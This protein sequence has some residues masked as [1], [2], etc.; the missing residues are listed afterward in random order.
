MHSPAWIFPK[1][2]GSSS[3]VLT[4]LDEEIMSKAASSPSRTAVDLNGDWGKYVH[5]KLMDTVTVPSSLRPSGLY[6]LRRNFLLPRLSNIQRAF[7]H[8][9][10]INYHGRVF[11]NGQ[12]LGTTIAFLPHEFDFTKV[13]TEGSNTVEVQIADALSEP[14]GTGKDDIAFS[15]SGGWEPS[16]G[17]IRDAYVEVR[18]SAF[19]DNVRFGYKLGAGYSSAA[20]TAKV[21]VSSA[22]AHSGECELSLWWRNTEIAQGK[23]ALDLTPGITEA[24][25]KFDVKTLAL[26]SPEDP[27]LYELR[28]TLTTP[29][30]E[31]RWKTRTGFREIKTEGRIFV[32][33]G[34]RFVMNGICRHDTWKDQGFT[35]SRQ[36]QEKD[37]RM[38]KAMGCNFVRLV[39]Y[40][41]DRRIIELADEIGLFVSEEPGFYGN[42][43]FA[44][45]PSTEIDLG[46]HILQGEIRRDWNSPSVMIWLLGNECAFPVSYLKKGKTICDQL[47]PIGRLVS[48]AHTYGNFPGVKDTFDEAGMDFYDWH[49]YEYEDGKFARLAKS[50]GPDKPLTFTEWGWEVAGPKAVFYEPDFDGLLELVEAG[51]VAGHAFW[52]WNDVR[53][54]NRK[55]WSATNGLLRSGAVTEDREIRQPIYGRL[56]ALF[57][58]RREAENRPAPERPT[59]LPLRTSPFVPGSIFQITDLQPLADSDSGRLSWHALQGELENFWGSTRMARNQWKRTGAKFDLWQTP[60]VKIAGVVF[61]S[62]LVDGR[63]RPVVLTTKVSEVTI[64]IQQFCTALHILGQVSFGKGY[65]LTGAPDSF[66]HAPA[67][68]DNHVGDA[69]AEYS[70][71]YAGGK[72]QVLPVRNGIEIAQANRIH[73]ASRILP[74]ATSA[75]PALEYIKDVVREQYQIL[76]WSMPTQKGKLERIACKLAAP[77]NLAI[78][79]ITTEDA[80]APLDPKKRR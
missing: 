54:Y 17:I 20:C 50:C 69:V 46:C 77:G 41:H 12:D 2:V 40:P 55:D 8:F 1:R 64:P 37:M 42:M 47:D 58:G 60:E 33:N 72:T 14:D 4:I 27:N 78:F 10:A 48:V 52:S 63:V 6:R 13:A 65:P 32:L 79:A 29:A 74:I 73:E 61:R 30:G 3:K 43:D 19:I 22:D 57:G 71:H 59:I 53:E 31:D 75:Q 36:Q 76:L 26:W 62:P 28:A 66:G 39:H 70:L 38:I 5:G 9:D 80:R 23:A 67:T 21:F 35:L 18:P 45:M 11:V 7:A 24:E 68:N 16:G 25:I 15:D 49:A 34:E 51:K 56:A 44:K